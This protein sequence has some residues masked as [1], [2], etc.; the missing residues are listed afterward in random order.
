MCV[1]TVF[2]LYFDIKMLN[3]CCFYIFHYIL[4]CIHFVV[5][6]VFIVLDTSFWHY[7]S[8]SNKIY[9]SN[10]THLNSIFIANHFILPSKRIRVCSGKKI[11][12][13]FLMLGEAYTIYIH[14]SHSHVISRPF[15]KQQNQSRIIFV[16]YIYIL[17]NNDSQY[18]IE[19]RFDYTHSSTQQT[20]HVYF[21]I[22]MDI[23]LLRLL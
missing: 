17:H 20:H 14:Y 6:V 16:T 21:F 9:N 10:S 13:M 1:C 23:S 18:Q 4:L 19:I 7:R 22:T 12:L 2:T 3:C 5:V 15:D 8:L 11:I